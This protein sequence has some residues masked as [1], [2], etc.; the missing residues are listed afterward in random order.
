MPRAVREEK[1]IRG[2]NTP[3]TRGGRGRDR[4][5]VFFNSEARATGPLNPAWPVAVISAGILSADE[6]AQI[7]ALQ[8]PPALASRHGFISVV[9]GA[10]HN[11]LL[12]AKY[13]GSIVEG[14]DFV[15]GAHQEI[16]AGG[17]RAETV[18]RGL[19]VAKG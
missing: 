13:S 3:C 4:A 17:Q 8:P 18:Y 6:G 9:E 16:Q 2:Q 5:R 14:I 15:L 10:T 11:G 7:Q 12:G 1:P 19:S